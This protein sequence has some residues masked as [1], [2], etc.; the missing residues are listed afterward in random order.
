M[1][2][3]C[4]YWDEGE[5]ALREVAALTFK[6]L[7]ALNVEDDFEVRWK[8]GIGIMRWSGGEDTR[9]CE[10]QKGECER[11]DGCVPKQSAKE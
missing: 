10:A 5:L 6:K 7:Q 4:K 8:D 3:V 9:H 2:T 1:R 11:K